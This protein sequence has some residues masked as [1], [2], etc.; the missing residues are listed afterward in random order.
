[1]FRVRSPE[2]GRRGFTLI[3]LLVVIAIIA[4]L[5]GLLLPAV[6]KVREAA[7]RMSSGNNLKQIALGFHN[8]NDSKGKL[9]QTYGW[10]PKLKAGEEYVVDGYL[11][12]GFFFLLPYI[13]QDNLLRSSLVTQTYYYYNGPAQTNTYG[14]YTYNVGTQYEYT[15]SSTTAYS[16][17][18]T[19]RNRDANNKLLSI[20]AYWG[21]TL[22][23]VS[24]SIFRSS[25]D[26]SNTSTSTAYS[27]Y[28]MNSA[29]FDKELALQQISD[30]TSNTVLV[31]EGYASCSS[32]VRSGDKNQNTRST[33]RYSYWP[34]YWYNYSYTSSTI[35]NWKGSYYVN[36]YGPTMES[37]YSANYYTPKFDPIFGK[38]PE[39]RPALGQCD[40]SMPQ[41]FSAGGTQVAL[42]DG[43]VRLISPGMDPKT[44]YGSTTPTGGEVLANW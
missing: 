3:E 35:Y 28:L 6:Q 42:G 27:S 9:P 1:M 10:E 30:G 12:S 4:I 38:T 15:Y 39:A 43:S 36:L 5:I 19:Y 20:R 40:G 29:V 37:T 18:P 44:W 8:Y 33:S 23:N 2:R 26:P 22:S 24:L 31:A 25:A 17:Y 14:P 34:G 21:P 11:G 13:E 32:S 41:G 7:A 16:A